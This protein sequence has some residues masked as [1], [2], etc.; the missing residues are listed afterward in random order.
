M[1]DFFVN[2][3]GGGAQL[4]TF[5]QFPCFLT[6]GALSTV[7]AYGEVGSSGMKISLV[8]NCVYLS[9]Y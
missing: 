8:Q 1:R 7:N 2:G 9:E 3:E 5:K 6:P 4:N